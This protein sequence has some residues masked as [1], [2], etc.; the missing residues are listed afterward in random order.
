MSASQAQY[1]AP[2]PQGDDPAPATVPFA[3]QL[4]GILHTDSTTT[5]TAFHSTSA[6]ATTEAALYSSAHIIIPATVHASPTHA[7]GEVPS[8]SPQFQPPPQQ[9]L[10]VYPG[11]PQNAAAAPVQ[12]KTHMNTTQAVST[13]GGAPSQAH[14]VG[15]GTTVDDVGTFNGGSYR[16][17][18]R[19]TNTVLTIQLAMGCPLTVKPGAMIAM[20]PTMTL[21]GAVKFSLK[22][23]AIGG[24]MSASTFTG[25]GELLLAPASLGDITNI[26]L[27]GSETWSVG[28]DAFLACTQG[29]TKDYKAQG[30]SKAIFSGEGLFTFKMSGVGLVWITSLGAIIR[31]DLQAGEKYII[32]NGHLV[33]WNCDYKLERIASGGIISNMSAGEGLI[34]KFTGEYISLGI[35]SEKE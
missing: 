22:K 7:V 9:S 1:F 18:H 11:P 34:C 15:A 2:P 16:V 24:Q 29:V 4:A 3:G 20:S 5:A 19:D 8:P 25:P 23:L 6:T 31:K 12:E 17:S 35:R 21:K 10:P 14:F 32:D 27:T 13:P 28:K 30:I 26:R 33:A